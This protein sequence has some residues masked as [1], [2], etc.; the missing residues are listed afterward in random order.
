MARPP[1]KKEESRAKLMQVRVQDREYET[2]KEAAERAGLDL[3]AWVRERLR[4]AARKDLKNDTY[5]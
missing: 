4:N 3:S 1:K 5:L 2:F